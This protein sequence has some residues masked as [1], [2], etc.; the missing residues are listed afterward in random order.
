MSNFLSYAEKYRIFTSFSE[1]TETS[2]SND[3]VNFIFNNS[4]LKRKVAVRELAQ[5]GNGYVYGVRSLEN[6]HINCQ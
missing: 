1:L 6:C 5:S 3:R 4:K 2:I